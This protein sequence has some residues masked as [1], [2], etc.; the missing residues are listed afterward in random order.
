MPHSL[1]VPFHAADHR[2]DGIARSY[3]RHLPL[4][5]LCW[6]GV[7]LLEASQVFVNDASRG[8][9]LSTLH[10]LAWPAFNWCVFAFISPLIYELGL[11]YPIVGQ[12]W[13]RRLFLP[14]SIV[15]LV[16]LVA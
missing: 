4:S 15:C 14:H 3:L 9:I 7:I 13:V 5:L 1:P 11:R 16:C 2:N 8:Y 6:V 10:Y 12:H